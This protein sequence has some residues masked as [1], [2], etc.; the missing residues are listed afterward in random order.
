MPLIF[1]IHLE[2]WAREC[3]FLFLFAIKLNRF[4]E[5]LT[6]K[7]R[8]LKDLSNIW[9]LLHHN[10]RIFRIFAPRKKQLQWKKKPLKTSTASR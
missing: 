9:K 8:N 3:L 7:Q 4:D 1:S 10:I 5:K 6:K 2:E